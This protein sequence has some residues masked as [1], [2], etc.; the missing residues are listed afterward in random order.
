M[1]YAATCDMFFKLTEIKHGTDVLTGPLGCLFEKL[2]DRLARGDA[3][4]NT[5]V[6]RPVDEIDSRT[7]VRFLGFDSIISETKAAANITATFTAGDGGTGTVVLGKY[8]ASGWRA[9]YDKGDTLAC[10]QEYEMEDTTLS[11]TITM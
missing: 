9:V 6:C 3:G 5:P 4:Q 11:E 8:V 1:A 10:E 2:V 7:S